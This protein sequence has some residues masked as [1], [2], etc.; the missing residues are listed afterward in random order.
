MDLDAAPSTKVFFDRLIDVNEN[1]DRNKQN[2]QTVLERCNHFQ[3][4]IE[5]MESIKKIKEDIRTFEE[6]Q[7]WMNDQLDQITKKCNTLLDQCKQYQR[8]ADDK[9][10][11]ELII[12]TK[13]GIKTILDTLP[14]Q[15]ADYIGEQIR[16]SKDLSINMDNQLSIQAV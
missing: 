7:D 3:V 10:E 9:Y 16:T 13:T 14:S 5:N 11:I 2:S 4:K 15:Q 6:E 1:I 12:Q 8:Y